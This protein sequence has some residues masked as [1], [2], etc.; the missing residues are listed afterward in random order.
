MA[1]PKRWRDFVT[2]YRAHQ[3]YWFFPKGRQVNSPDLLEILRV[4]A[5]F[6]GQA[7]DAQAI[8]HRLKAEK[9]SSGALA[10]PRMI[11][12]ALENMGMLWVNQAGEIRITPFGN[13]YLDSS[14]RQAMLDRHLWRYSLPNPLNT[15]PGRTSL[16]P[17]AFL[18]RTLLRVGDRISHDEF[19]LFVARAR[20]ATDIDLVVADIKGWRKLSASQRGEVKGRLGQL[21]RTI[22]GDSSYSIGFHLCASDIELWTDEDHR[23]GIK[24]VD[25]KRQTLIDRLD[26]HQEVAVPIEFENA[27]QCVAVF[28]DPEAVS[29][30]P[31]AVERYLDA[32][33]YTKA[34]EAF[35]A[36]PPIARNGKSVE[37]FRE[38][39]FLEKDLEDYLEKNLDLI[40]TGLKKEGM[41]RQHSTVVGIIDLFARAKN[42]DLVVIEL[43]K[44]RASD[45]VFGQLCRYVGCITKHYADPKQ[46]VRGYIIGSDIDEKLEYA[47]SVLGEPSVRPPSHH[48]RSNSAQGWP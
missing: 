33:R 23:I 30:G 38:E 12:R 5:E 44:G 47:A 26:I 11:K 20:Q 32:S 13:R 39:V 35:A 28:G 4:F 42:G 40:E 6:D 43:K 41:G 22:E 34:V 24:I 31:E 48:E 17:H 7:W 10:V 3:D 27:A 19:V 29:E 16:F 15:R 36:L 46:T 14:D 9:L 1:L 21:R 18:I 45:K 37:E 25:G 2:R 8:L